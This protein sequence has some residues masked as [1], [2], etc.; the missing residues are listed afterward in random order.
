MTD[1]TRIDISLDGRI[2]SAEPGETVLSVAKR[3]GI[4]IP[5]LCHHEALLPSGACRLCVVEIAKETGLDS[6][7]DIAAA[8]QYPV[9][10]GL[11]VQTNSER[12]RRHRR[13]IISLL[14]AR[15]P[16]VAAFQELARTFG[17][18]IAYRASERQDDCILCTLC[19]RT[20]AAV[21]AEAISP[22]GR[23]YDKQIAPPFVFGEGGCVGCGACFRACPTGCID[24]VDTDATRTIWNH[25]FSLVKCT[26]CGAPTVTEDYMH[27]AMK[28]TGLSERYFTQ[29]A[30]C[31]RKETATT[32]AA[33]SAP[34]STGEE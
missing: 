34:L 8:C 20:C 2:V 6:E 23:G 25:E 28:R 12:I 5:S 3:H 22:T 33:L 13:V 11:I 19:T 1:S 21:G 26:T 29:C 32:F 27:F 7:R 30:A 18:A 10:K 9:S 4:D 24:M 31:K 17:G 16:H 14:L 15:A